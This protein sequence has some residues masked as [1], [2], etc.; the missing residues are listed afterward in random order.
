MLR[1]RLSIL[2]AAACAL[3]AIPLAAANG[4]AAKA[5]QKAT[6]AMRRAWKPETLSGEIS[7]VNADR[8]L[9][10]VETTDGVP[11]DMVVT[12]KTR[13]Q[14]GDQAVSLKEL[15]QD[16][17]KS[18]SVTFTPERRGDVAKTIEI[19]GAV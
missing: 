16:T 17:N 7:M 18:I 9:V 8:R 11:F 13:I 4:P 15:T 19:G 1:V 14:S 5:D 12:G 2:A 3:A 6:A 10:V